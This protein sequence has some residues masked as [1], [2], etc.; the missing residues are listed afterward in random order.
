MRSFNPTFLLCIIV[1]ILLFTTACRNDKNNDNP[2]DELVT[3]EVEKSERIPDR[4]NVAIDAEY[5]ADAGIFNPRNMRWY[6]YRYASDEPRKEITS[7]NPVVRAENLQ[8]RQ[9]EI[10]TE[11]VYEIS[12]T[13]RP[14]LF[15]KNCLTS[16]NPETCSNEAVID[17]MKYAVER[18]QVTDLP[19]QKP[20]HFVTFLINEKGSVSAAKI[21]AIKGQKPCEPC[22]TATLEAIAGMSDWMPAIRNGRAV[23][24]QVTFPVYYD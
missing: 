6:T 7:E 14:P 12:E 3:E 20:V 8:E 9:G 18:P 11:E 16:A 17:W 4:D 24:V 1:N 5:I 2:P 15:N 13:S 10:Q 19:T 21:L 23:K 22:N